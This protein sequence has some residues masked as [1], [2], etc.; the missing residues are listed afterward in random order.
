MARV[1]DALDLGE[2]EGKLSPTHL[3]RNCTRAS[4]EALVDASVGNAKAFVWPD[5]GNF[6]AAGNFRFHADHE[7]F[8]PLLIDKVSASMMLTL[9]RALNEP[10]QKRF[11]EFVGAG[12]GEFAHL[13]ELT[14]ERVKITD[15]RPT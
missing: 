2:L 4:Y 12:R 15:F 10:N 13:F 14:Q 1:V 5:E 3:Y 8:Q 9:Y 6:N 7:G 11:R